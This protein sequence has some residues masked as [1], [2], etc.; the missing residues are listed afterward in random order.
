M[1]SSPLSKKAQQNTWRKNWNTHASD[2]QIISITHPWAAN[3][4]VLNKI[5]TIIGN[6][7]PFSFSCQYRNVFG[8]FLSE[9]SFLQHMRRCRCYFCCFSVDRLGS[10]IRIWY[11]KLIYHSTLS[12]KPIGCKTITRRNHRIFIQMHAKIIIWSKHQK[13]APY[14]PF[15]KKIHQHVDSLI[16]FINAVSNALMWSPWHDGYG[17]GED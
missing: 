1:K 7:T 9:V 3:L 2:I 11:L 5:I 15:Y 4:R 6:C 13:A 8:T 10:R 16:H 14:N 17:I 12:A